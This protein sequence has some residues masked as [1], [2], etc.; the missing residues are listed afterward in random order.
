MTTAE[1]IAIIGEAD[2]SQ[3]RPALAR[4][5]GESIFIEDDDYEGYAV[6]TLRFADG[7]RLRVCAGHMEAI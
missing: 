2:S 7:S 3:F 6:M 1:N 5:Q 4:A